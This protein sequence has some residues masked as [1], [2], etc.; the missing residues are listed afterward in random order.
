MNSSNINTFFS[1][2][3]GSDDINILYTNIRSLRKNFNAFLLELSQ[4]NT[5][6]SI[7]VL[8]EV[9]INS[10]EA[11]F[12]KIP[13]FT[14]FHCCNDTYRAG[15]VMCFIAEDIFSL[16]LTVNFVSADT[17]LVKLKQGNTYFNLF[18]I[19]RLQNV[20]E[21]LF[22]EELNAFLATLRNNTILIGDININL[23][24][25]S[26]IVLNYLDILNSYGFAQYVDKPTRITQISETCID[27]IFIRNSCLSIFECDI[28][29]IHL[30]DH[31]LL[32]LKMKSFNKSKKSN[33]S[34]SNTQMQ[35]LD[36]VMLSEKLLNYDWA[37]LYNEVEVNVCF[38]KFMEVLLEAISS[39][40]I[41]N[42]QPNKLRK[43]MS[44]SPWINKFLLAKLNKKKKL[45]KLY[46]QRPYDLNFKHYFKTFCNKLSCDID[47]AKNKF[48]SKEFE[49]CQGDTA[50]QWKL[51]NRLTGRAV[52]NSVDSVELDNGEILGEPEKIAEEINSFLIAEQS[53]IPSSRVG[54]HNVRRP[55]DLPQTAHSF[56][57]SPTTEVEVKSVINK[58]K[59]KKSSGYDCIN[60][61]VIKKIAQYIS[62]ILTHIINLSFENGVFPEKLK[63]SIVVPI[64][65]K[66]SS[67]KINDLRPISLL[68][69]FSKILEKL[70]KA[71]LVR[72][73]DNLNFL[74]KNQF[75]FRKGKSTED[76]L[77]M[78][79]EIIYRGLNCGKKTTGL[80]IDFQKAFDLV[81]HS[82]LLYKLESIGVRGVAFNW[83][84]TF[85]MERQQKVKIKNF[86]SAPLVVKAGVPQGSVLSATLF[87]IFIN[88]LLEKRF[89]GSPSA[90]ADD[91]AIFYTEKNFQTLE[92]GILHDIELLRNWCFDNKMKINVNKSKY[93]NFDFR[94]Y[95]FDTDLKF[96]TYSCPRGICNCLSI[97]KVDQYK[98]LGV[99][100]D[101][102]LSWEK[103]TTLLRSKLKSCIR[104]FYFLNNL[105][106]E[107][108]MIS[109]YYALIHSRLQYAIQC[110]GGTFKY[111]IDKLRVAQNSF[112]RIILRKNRRESSF[113]LFRQLNILPVQHLF[114]FK[115]LRLFFIRSGNTGTNNLFYNTRSLSRNAFRLPKVNRSFFRQSYEYIGPK[116]FNQLPMEVRNCGRVNLFVTKLKRWLFS[117]ENFNF[118]DTI[119]I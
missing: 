39:C 113:P 21:N 48:Y 69:V 46:K 86:V 114:I 88:D 104:I 83:F 59:N 7:I 116:Y 106:N 87:L 17:L 97:E 62:P 71:R 29:D 54:L 51:I 34:I 11:S 55:L 66:Q 93:I 16:Q 24:N 36:Y 91:I 10:E 77:L 8:T 50:M 26:Q 40:K 31:C 109:L 2:G 81:D 45:Y 102:R 14:M 78:V 60:V 96:H 99:L 85:L 43:A 117:N 67:I 37:I 98:Y 82:I 105:C 15:G 49:N 61:L 107:N 22:L 84:K 108:L 63:L 19:Y 119:L 35:K 38:N 47:Q 9:W 13:N 115:V 56:F 27:H 72:Y 74:N 3:S 75:G 5:R 32:G 100:L 94:G 73:L 110:W 101:E 4:I 90:F 64:R 76:A 103:H 52:K 57:I 28:F 1:Q 112:I 80:F 44:I 118:L 42:Q 89:A 6:I 79:T 33:C 12:Y 41:E 65:K 111:N 20:A 68:S 30:T 23:L 25:N 95:E 92:N 18:C 53:N 58:L 70:M